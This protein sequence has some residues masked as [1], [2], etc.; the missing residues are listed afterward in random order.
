MLMRPFAC[1]GILVEEGKILL[2][3]RAKEPDL[4]KWAIPGGRIEENETAEECLKREFRE[5][6][7]FEIEPVK[8]VGIYSDPSRDPRKIIGAVYIV[9]RTRG[10]IK[11]GDDAGEARWFDLGE[12][13]DELA[14]DHKKIVDDSIPLL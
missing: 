11:A 12:I 5:E 4:G 6:T 3:K 2:I 1:D 8:L 9:K 13:P 14:F 7:G 10:E